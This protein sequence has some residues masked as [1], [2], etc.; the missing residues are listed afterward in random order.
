M[1]SGKKT[2]R[3]IAFVLVFAFAVFILSYA[4]YADFDLDIYVDSQKLESE[5]APFIEDGSTYVPLRAVSEKI[6]ADISWDEERRVAVTVKGDITAELSNEKSSIYRN[7][8]EVKIGRSPKIVNDRMYVPLRAIAEGFG[9]TVS[10][11]GVRRIINIS[12]DSL[13]KVHFLDCGQADSSFIELP[14]GKCMLIDAGEKSFGKDLVA[15]IKDLGYKKLDYVVATHPHTDHIG[16]MAEVLNSFEV[17]TFYAPYKAHNT[18]TFEDTLYAL[19]RNGCKAVFIGQGD[20]LFD[21]DVKCVCLSPDGKEYSRINNYSA[22]LRLSYKDVS[23]LFSA[24]AEA[25]SEDAML[26]SSLVL[27]SN[28]LKVGHH[29]SISSSTEEYI[30]AI[31][32]NVAVISVGRDNE[33]GFPAQHVLD[34]F[35][36]RDVKVYRTDIHG[37][38]TLLTDGYI[39]T[40]E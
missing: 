15:L 21:G 25:D 3:N 39:Y 35:S 32:P 7:G 26:N 23:V 19:M 27:D 11:D 22:V 12:S 36:V 38:I 28:V 8:E 29:G 33:Y 2:F 9:Y 5:F 18:K 34:T 30:D 16:G 6:G 40:M 17:D 31:S 4:V 14:D 1:M 37:N 24:D 13:L 20:I 10:Y